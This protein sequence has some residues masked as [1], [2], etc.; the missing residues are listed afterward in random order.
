MK[1]DLQPR[2]TPVEREIHRKMM[3]FCIQTYPKGF[4]L[5]KSFQRLG[6][7]IARTTGRSDPWSPSYVANVYYGQFAKGRS[8]SPEFVK[9]LEALAARI[10]GAKA[11]SFLLAARNTQVQTWQDN[12]LQGAFVMG[13]A[14]QC[15]HPGCSIMFVGSVP[16]RK[17]CPE[18]SPFR[19]L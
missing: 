18:C 4:S 9:G 13:S 12:D 6:R 1:P 10:E 19:R 7:D 2:G 8:A 5:R 14:K 16:W 15:A 3:D 17:Y 11:P